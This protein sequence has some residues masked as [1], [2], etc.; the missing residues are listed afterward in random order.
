MSAK[1]LQTPS[2]T[3]GPYF[4]YGLTPGQYGYNFPGIVDGMMVDKN[5]EGNVVQIIGTV[6]DAE[7]KSVDDAMLEL[8]QNDGERRLFGRYGTG[9]DEG[10][11]FSFTT[12][13]PKSVDGQAPFINVIIFMRGQLLH[14]YTR[15]YFEDE[16]TLN[17]TDETLN[18]IPE[19]RRKTI[20]AKKEDGR[21]VFDIYMQGNHETVFFQ[22]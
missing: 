3:I 14:S 5:D 8:W 10:N 11:K 13:K 6:Y 19:D 17:A 7:G 20:I 12:V 9:T 1:K 15:I 16:E 18:S 22:L 21:Y 2:Q 4:A